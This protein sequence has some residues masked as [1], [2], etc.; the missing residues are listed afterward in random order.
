MT[1][2]YMLVGL[3]CSGKSFFAKGQGGMWIS[4]DKIR[5]ELYGNESIQ[6]N[7]EKVFQVMWERLCESI[8]RDE[9]YVF[10]DATNVVCKRRI[11]FCEQLR[12]KYGDKIKLV[13]RVFNTPIEECIRRAKERKERPLPE[14]VIW[15]F[16]KTWQTPAYWEGWD[17][18]IITRENELD[19]L[20][21][22]M[23][24]KIQGMDQKNKHHFLPL[25]EHM[26]EA[27]RNV[28]NLIKKEGD[29]IPKVSLEVWTASSYHDIGKPLVQTFDDEGFVHYYAHENVSGYLTLGFGILTSSLVSH[30][31][32]IFKKTK[33][34]NKMN[35][36]FRHYLG[37]M[38]QADVAAH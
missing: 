23:L 25:D 17:T 19:P 34:L 28:L 3:P 26:K 36:P 1:N 38:Y 18:I 13:A 15:K 27:G 2:V 6:E 14:S 5:E 16:V 21:Y 32:D 10:Y 12:K 35:V 20:F 11:V 24:D 29:L 30:H 33:L 4:S 31:M 22:K 9:E 37:L 7:P 8:E